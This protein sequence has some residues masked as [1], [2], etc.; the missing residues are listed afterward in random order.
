MKRTALL[1]ALTVSLLIAAQVALS[2]ITS[3][4]KELRPREKLFRIFQKIKENLRQR[5]DGTDDGETLPCA[6]VEIENP[7]SGYLYIF[8][9]KIFYLGKDYAI[10]IGRQVIIEG[11]ACAKDSLICVVLDGDNIYH[12]VYSEEIK[13]FG[14]GDFRF[15]WNNATRGDYLIAVKAVSGNEEDVDYVGVKI[16]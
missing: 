5:G 7:Q 4:I 14:A 15:I 1:F 10:I 16:L 6:C 2:S 9:R 8:G 13:G 11:I 3:D 12:V